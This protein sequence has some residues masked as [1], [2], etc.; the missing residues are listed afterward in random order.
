ME[1][2][3]KKA[4]NKCITNEQSEA[5]ARIEKKIAAAIQSTNNRKDLEA[6]I[7]EN[8]PEDRA[9]SVRMTADI[10]RGHK[11]LYTRRPVRPTDQEIFDS[12]ENTQK[13]RKETGLNLGVLPK[14]PEAHLQGGNSNTGP[15][16][17]PTA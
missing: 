15:S 6:V 13:V 14:S 12:K 11:K 4:R 10:R 3:W 8:F 17:G 7:T 1:L 2:D 9:K 5:Q 16:K